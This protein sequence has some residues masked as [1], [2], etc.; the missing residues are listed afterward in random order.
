M[1]AK[2]KRRGIYLWPNLLPQ[3]RCFLVLPLL[4]V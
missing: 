4:P 3:Q 2:V 1:K